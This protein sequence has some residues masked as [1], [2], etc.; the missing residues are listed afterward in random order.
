MQ[1]EPREAL[2]DIDSSRDVYTFGIQQG[3]IVHEICAHTSRREPDTPA[4]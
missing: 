4:C 1:H 2:S 3:Y